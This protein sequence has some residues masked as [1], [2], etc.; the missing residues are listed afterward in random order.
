MTSKNVQT[1]LDILK[2]E[3]RGDVVAALAKMAPGY[4]MTWAYKDRKGRLFPRSTPDFK[5]EMKD[6]Y[7]IKGREYAIKH[8]AEGDGV[9][10]IE[11]VESYPDSET[12]K[13]YRTPL[14]LALEFEEGKIVRGRHYCDPQLS[15]LNLSQED[16]DSLYK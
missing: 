11:L 15:Y 3:I 16:I 8:V 6:I 14:V 9:V 7:A 4:S 2:D 12:G 5:A 10:M 13:I 1:S